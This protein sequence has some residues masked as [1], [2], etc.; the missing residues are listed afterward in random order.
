[1]TDETAFPFYD[2]YANSIDQLSHIRRTGKEVDDVC[3]SEH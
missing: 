2:C 1:M 3:D